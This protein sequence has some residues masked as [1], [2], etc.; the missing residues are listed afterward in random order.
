MAILALWENRHLSMRMPIARSVLALGLSLLAGV[1]LLAQSRPGHQPPAVKITADRTLNEIM[2]ETFEPSAGVVF[3]VAAETPKT[4]REW[5]TVEENAALLVESARWLT[6]R[7]K[8]PD[9]VR[10]ARTLVATGTQAVKAAKA[11]NAGGVIAAGDKIVTTCERCHE[12]YLK[13]N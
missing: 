1:S 2:N 4:T 9:W 5:K 12:K 8:D 7:V 6:N 13:R 10:F 3:Y 11:R